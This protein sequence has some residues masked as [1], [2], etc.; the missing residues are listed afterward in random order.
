MVNSLGVEVRR[1]YVGTLQTGRWSFEWD[2]HGG[3]GSQVAAGKY[4]IQVQSE[5]MTQSREVNIR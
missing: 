4:F 1:M 3:D 5:G 2:G